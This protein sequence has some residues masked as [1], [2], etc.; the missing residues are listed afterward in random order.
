M[1][2]HMLPGDAQVEAFV[3][4]GIEGEMLV[5]R[6]ALVEGDV[7]GDSLDVFFNNRAAFHNSTSD[8]GPAN[9]NVNVASQFKRLLDAGN[10]DE[11]N[12]WFEYELFCAANMWFCLDLLKGTRANIFRVAPAHLNA[13]NRW[14]GFGGAGAGDMRHCFEKRTRLTR[15]DVK[16]G[17]DL[18][19]A[20]KSNDRNAL[21][22]LSNSSTDAFPYLPDV[23]GAAANKG[24]H[25]AAV[26]NE[27]KSEGINNFNEIFM[28]FRRR[29]G[30]YG[31][32][33]S[34]VKRIMSELPA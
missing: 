29:A 26:I 27:I 3:Q 23:G 30:V 19:H 7:S 8:E 25:P 15:D 28:E 31:Y 5:C 18:W 14:D 34:Q 20:F 6:E 33:D 9:Y 22:N 2:Y 10:G 11:V 13:A 32:G 17:T 4:S 1:V 21:L 24:D 12:L 16:L